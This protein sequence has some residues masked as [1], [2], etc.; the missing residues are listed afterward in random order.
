MNT[1]LEKCN[2]N[3]CYLSRRNRRYVRP[4]GMPN[5]EDK[6]MA[7]K[8]PQQSRQGQSV[9]EKFFLD[10]VSA[11]TKSSDPFGQAKAEKVQKVQW[12][13][14]LLFVESAEQNVEASQ[15]FAVPNPFQVESILR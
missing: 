13:P 7:A 11:T 2:S 12:L 3:S 6:T 8:G 5:G 1:E 10:F 14:E 15:S 9:R 4:A